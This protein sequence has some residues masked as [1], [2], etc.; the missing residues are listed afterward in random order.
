MKGR[1]FLITIWV[2][3]GNYLWSQYNIFQCGIQIYTTKTGWNISG[4]KITF[5]E[6]YT[7]TKDTC[8]FGLIY[9]ILDKEYS[10]QNNWYPNNPKRVL[11]YFDTIQKNHYIRVYKNKVGF[12][13]ILC[14]KRTNFKYED[15]LTQFKR[16]SN[17]Y[18]NKMNNRICC[19]VYITTNMIH[20]ISN[21]NN[22]QRD[23]I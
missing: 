21:Q 7:F 3:L 17:W 12:N 20:R 13:N 6:R 1:L 16:I 19:F 23:C 5:N 11:I 2:L 10:I 8:I 9:I 22:E 15:I 4:N 14:Y 18:K